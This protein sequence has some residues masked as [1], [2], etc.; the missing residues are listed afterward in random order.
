MSTTPRSAGAGYAVVAVA[1]LTFG[2]LVIRLAC[3]R[4]DLW[5][6]EIWSLDIASHANSAAALLTLRHDNNHA[7]NSLWLWAVGPAGAAWWLRLP[8]CFGGAATV[9]GAAWLGWLSASG[10]QASSERRAAV[11]GFLVATSFFF[12]HY[13]SEARGYA[14]AGAFGVFALAVAVRAGARPWSALAPVYW[15]LAAL[16]LLSHATAIHIVVGVAAWSAVVAARSTESAGRAALAWTWWNLPPVM[17]IIAFRVFFLRGI[18]IG[19]GNLYELVPELTRGL[20]ATAGLPLNTPPVLILSAGAASAAI[21]LAALFH[22]R[23]DMWI[24]YLVVGV[25][26]PLILILLSHPGFFYARY[27]HLSL[28]VGLLLATEAVTSLAEETPAILPGIIVAMAFA[29]IVNLGHTWSLLSDG[30][31]RYREALLHVLATSPEGRIR[32]ASDHDFRNGMV[33]DYHARRLGVEANIEYVASFQS[34]SE[35][36]DWVFLHTFERD[37]AVL[38]SIRDVSGRRYRF[39]SRFASGPLSGWQWLLYRRID[40]P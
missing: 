17:A 16:A 39:D 2:A 7:L 1:A 25:V 21:G 28:L 11:A 24:L 38:P 37:P 33:I 23:C 5:L 30:R 6:D 31:G 40:G 14:L 9:V 20:A 34:R 19:G 13:G 22:R 12:V 15:I 36:V 32:V 4:G 26:S 8:A 18:T 29:L 10:N 3:A 35:R 27:F